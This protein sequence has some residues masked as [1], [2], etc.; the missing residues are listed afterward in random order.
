MITNEV[1]FRESGQ[2]D[3]ETLQR[4]RIERYCLSKISNLE[5]CAALIELSLSRNE[6]DC[7]FVRIFFQLMGRR[8]H[9]VLAITLFIFRVDRINS[10]ARYF[11]EFNT[12]RLILQ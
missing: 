1:I 8:I 11:V 3:K 9:F 6:V 10:G 7:V 5:S 12:I 4:L 2:Y